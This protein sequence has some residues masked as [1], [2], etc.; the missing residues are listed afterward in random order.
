MTQHAGSGDYVHG[1][2]AAAQQRLDDQAASIDDLVHGDTRL[3]PGSRVVELGCATGSQTLLLADLLHPGGASLIAVDRSAVMLAEA[4]RR[5]NA[6]GHPEVVLLQADAV[7]LPLADASVD[8]VVIRF[9]LEH[10]PDPSAVLRSAQ[11]ILKP[12]GRIM[13]IEGDHGPTSFHPDDPAAHDAIDCQVE[14][15]RRLGGDAM[16][17]RRLRPLLLE[18]GFTDVHVSPRLVHADGGRPGLQDRFTRRTF[19]A[20]IAG[21]RDDALAAG[22]IAAERFDAGI[23]ALERTAEPDGVFLYLFMKATATRPTP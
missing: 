22:L 21:V 14:L 15:Q 11:R 19:T 20:M 23:A 18:A 5:L 16:I 3:E 8:Q 4:R 7:D 17:G 1:F 9:L 10:V 6:A 2:D 13:V 12:G